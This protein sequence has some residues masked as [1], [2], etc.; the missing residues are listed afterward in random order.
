MAQMM[1]G[2]RVMPSELLAGKKCFA[3]WI[4]FYDKQLADKYGS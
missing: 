4:Y 1:I 3:I 2:E